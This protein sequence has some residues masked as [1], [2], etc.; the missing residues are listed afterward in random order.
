M[1][2]LTKSSFVSLYP[3]FTVKNE[4]YH[5]KGGETSARANQYRIT[6]G[7]IGA[8]HDCMVQ[9]QEKATPCHV[10]KIVFTDNYVP[11]GPE[12]NELRDIMEITA[13]R[14]NG[15]MANTDAVEIDTKVKSN[16]KIA[17]GL[18]RCTHNEEESE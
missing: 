10:L 9:V 11:S 2:N 14:V 17:K 5:H 16:F 4:A 18:I 1:F 12:K 13:I 7:T 6:G 3:V 15:K 8:G